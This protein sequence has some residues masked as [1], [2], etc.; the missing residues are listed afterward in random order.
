[1]W[2]LSSLQREKKKE[3]LAVCSV[4]PLL[5]V[6]LAFQ[7]RPSEEERVMVLLGCVHLLLYKVGT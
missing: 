6:L 2:H 7:Q 3:H 4:N 5:Y 1:M